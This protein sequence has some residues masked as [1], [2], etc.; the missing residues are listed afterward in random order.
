MTTKDFKTRYN[1]KH[2]Y[3]KHHNQYIRED[4]K[5]TNIEDWEVSILHDHPE[6]TEDEL[7][8]LEAIWIARIGCHWPVGYN[9]SK[10]GLLKGKTKFEYYSRKVNCSNGLTYET[11]TEAAK[12]INGSARYILRQIEGQYKHTQGLTFAYWPQLPEPYNGY[13]KGKSDKDI[14]PIYCSNGEIYKNL[15]EASDLLGMEIRFIRT[16]IRKRA[17]RNGLRFS[18]TPKMSRDER[19]IPVIN[20]F[21][22]IWESAYAAGREL[23]CGGHCIRQVIKGKQKTVRGYKF[24]HYYGN[25]EDKPILDPNSRRSLKK[26]R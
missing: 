13:I 17:S 6:M 21:G 2:W 7:S 19:K 5:Y 1:G 11:I 26:T 16:S 20:N 24:A 8:E 23:G 10:V 14:G 3:L 4:C 22:Q 9:I 15:R 25:L 12:D 18:E